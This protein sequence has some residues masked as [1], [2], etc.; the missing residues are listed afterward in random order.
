M[1]ETRNTKTELV[2]AYE[3]MRSLMEQAKPAVAM[4]EKVF[5][6]ICEYLAFSVNRK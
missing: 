3:E 1:Q 5:I 6:R 2:T 4:Y